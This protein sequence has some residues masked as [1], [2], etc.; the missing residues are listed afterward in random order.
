MVRTILFLGCSYP[1]VP[2]LI[3][4]LQFEEKVEVELDHVL[5]Q[6]TGVN[7]GDHVGIPKMWRSISGMIKGSI[8][9]NQFMEVRTSI[10]SWI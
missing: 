3:F 9:W 6:C 1:I 5:F 10:G 7:V 2:A 8:R 4:V